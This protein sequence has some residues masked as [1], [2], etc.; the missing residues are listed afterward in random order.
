MPEFAGLLRPLHWT[1]ES[2]SR[3]ISGQD[4]PHPFRKPAAVVG[5]RDV[6]RAGVL[7]TEAQ[8]CLTVPYRE[9]VHVRLLESQMLS[10]SVECTAV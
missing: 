10:A 5:Q 4:R 2:K 1:G 9:D 3:E 7:A 6:R 8:L